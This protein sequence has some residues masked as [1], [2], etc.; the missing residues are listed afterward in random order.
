MCSVRRKHRRI[1]KP[2]DEGVTQFNVTLWLAPGV[3]N[4]EST[5]C[6]FS[7]PTLNVAS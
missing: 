5:V 4:K 3:I 6:H 1:S 7:F 2:S